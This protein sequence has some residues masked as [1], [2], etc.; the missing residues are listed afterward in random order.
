MRPSRKRCCARSDVL[1]RACTERSGRGCCGWAA[2]RL[3]TSS[4]STSAATATAALR[5]NETSAGAPGAAES[6]I[7]CST[8]STT[9]AP[10]RARARGVSDMGRFPM[11]PV[12]DGLMGVR[13]RRAAEEGT[14]W[15]QCYSS[16][17]RERAKAC[18]S[19]GARARAHSRAHA[20]THAEARIADELALATVQSR[21]FLSAHRRVQP[22][23]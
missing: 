11:P 9:A 6:R 20:A 13:V 21:G 4:D 1:R 18:G 2:R 10:T 7:S 16:L 15:S 23:P 14:T 17:R 3:L 5:T 12:R 19:A 22:G 8:I